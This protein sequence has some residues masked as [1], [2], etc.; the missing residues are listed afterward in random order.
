M[1]RENAAVYLTY[2]SLI[3]IDTYSNLTMASPKTHS[4]ICINQKKK[5]KKI[6]VRYWTFYMKS[7]R[8]ILRTFFR[9][10][11][12][13]GTVAF[14]IIILSSSTGCNVGLSVIFVVE[15]FSFHIHR[16]WSSYVLHIIII[17]IIPPADPRACLN[18]QDRTATA[19]SCPGCG[20]HDNQVN[21]T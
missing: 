20:G 18:N 21:I 13:T 12:F 16:L 7:I 8:S 17:L 14:N 2:I 5:K 4:K 19:D 11:L 9:R 10:S 1:R 6:Y 15:F 3:I